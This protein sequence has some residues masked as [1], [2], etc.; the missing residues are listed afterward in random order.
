MEDSA[1]HLSKKCH[2]YALYD[3]LGFS[4]ITVKRQSGS[5]STHQANILNGVNYRNLADNE[6][7]WRLESTL[8]SSKSGQESDWEEYKSWS[9]T[10]SL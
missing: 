2:I 5:L 4:G 10:P 3:K 9:T 6:E 8:C 7:S 1:V